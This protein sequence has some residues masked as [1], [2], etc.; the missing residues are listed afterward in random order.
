MEKEEEDVRMA[1]LAI[2]CDTGRECTRNFQKVRMILPISYILILNTET[3]H[4][5]GIFGV[6]NLRI[7]QTHEIRRSKP[8]KTYLPLIIDVVI[9]LFFPS[10]SNLLKI[11]II[12][13]PLC[14]LAFLKSTP[15]PYLSLRGVWGLSRSTLSSCE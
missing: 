2:S 1:G 5:S 3:T 7:V 15:L 4:F 8:W 9:L 13:V 6:R 14:I 11:M 12:V 10:D